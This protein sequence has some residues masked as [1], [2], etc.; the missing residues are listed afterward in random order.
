[1]KDFQAQQKKQLKEH[2]FC[3]KV[4]RLVSGVEGRQEQ[5]LQHDWR[6]IK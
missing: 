6:W 3:V 2:K 5:S 4:S 1:M